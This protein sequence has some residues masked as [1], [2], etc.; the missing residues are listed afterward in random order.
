[1]QGTIGKTGLRLQQTRSGFNH[2][3]TDLLEDYRESLFKAE[4]NP[5]TD[6]YSEKELTAQAH[7]KSRGFP[8]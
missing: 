8:L 3:V 5:V 7:E 1:M 6:K 4:M 2:V